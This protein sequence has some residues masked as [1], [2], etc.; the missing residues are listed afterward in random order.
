MRHWEHFQTNEPIRFRSQLLSF[1]QLY[2]QFAF[3]DS[4]GNHVYGETTFDVLAGVGRLD[5]VVASAGEAFQAFNQFRRKHHDWMFG[6]FAYDLK[7]EVEVLHSDG[8]DGISLPDMIYFVPSILVR[9]KKQ[10]CGNW[11]H[12][13]YTTGYLGANL[14]HAG[15]DRGADRSADDDASKN[16]QSSIFGHHRQNQKSYYPW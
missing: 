6:F 3:L 16:E 12:C 7:N 1:C 9:I 5:E 11:H 14:L 15:A 4:C 13:S 8:Y 2:K 10:C